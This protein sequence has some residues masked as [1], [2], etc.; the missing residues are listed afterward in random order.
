[1][2]LARIGGWLLITGS[3]VFCVA[4]ALGLS[5]GRAGTGLD[6]LTLTFA[7]SIALAGLGAAAVTV[8]AVSPLH[9]QATRAGTG[10]IAVGL[11]GCV[12]FWLAL[13][14]VPPADPAAWLPRQEV[15]DLLPWLMVFLLTAALGWLVTGASIVGASGLRRWVGG[16]LLVGV[17]T[18][19]L[20]S[21]MS[22]T[23]P[24]VWA[25]GISLIVLGTVGIGVLAIRWPEPSVTL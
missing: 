12:V 14:S 7:I 10:I 15:F 22:R 21:T 3:A 9:T 8:A 17:P 20:G 1:M 11:L 13:A 2:K 4:V 19:A 25:L 18:T 6:P 24:A 16:L 23:E 5:V